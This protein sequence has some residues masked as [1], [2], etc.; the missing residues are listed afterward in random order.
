MSGWTSVALQRSLGRH[1]AAW[2]A[3]NRRAFGHHPLLTAL[4]V[5]GLLQKFG[6]GSE[7]LCRFE[8][9]GE[10]V[11]MCILRPKGRFLWTSFLPTQGQIAPT[12][13][14]D[15]ALVSDLWRSLPH[16]VV[17]I[18]LLCNDPLV[19]AVVTT[20]LPPTYRLNHALTISV[21]LEGSFE[22]Y[23]AA[24]PKQLRTNLKRYEKRLE[25]DGLSARL[26]HVTSADE[27]ADAV[28][29]YALLEDDGW[30]GRLGTSLGSSGP[31]YKF[32]RDLMVG[33]AADG[34]AS[35]HELWF[36]DTLVASRMI[37]AQQAT[38]VI[39]KTSYDER[40][41]VYA[42]GRMLLRAVIASSFAQNP[43]GTLE[44][45]TD[46]DQVQ[47]AWATDRRWIQHVSLFRWRFASPIIFALLSLY[48]DRRARLSA[49]R[50]VD[51][52]VEV[53][54][55]PAALPDGVRKFLER[56]E[57]RNF[58]FGFAWYCNLVATVYP[59]DDGIR[60]YTLHQGEHLL[61]VLP[62]RAQRV[63]LGWDLHA[64]G[65]F[66]TTLFEPVLEAG[67]KSNELI[68]LLVALQRDFP[69]WRSLTL[70][71]MD[72]A[73]DGYQTLL[74][75]MR[76]AGWFAFEFLG[77]ANW[78]QPAAE[79]WTDY[80]AARGGT[81]RSTI[82]RMTKKFA[83]DGGT[84]EIVTAS[85]EMPRAIAAYNEVY[86]ASWKRQEAFPDFM[87][88]LLQVCAEKKMLRLGLAWLNGK[89]IAAQAW[90][91]SHGRAEI[92]KVA[93]H[94][95]YKSYAPGTLVTAMLMQHVME[96]DHVREVDYL[97]GDDSYKKTWM[98]HRR[99]RWGIVAYNAGSLRGA[100]GLVYEILGRVAKIAMKDVRA[101]WT[102]VQSLRRKG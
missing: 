29:R 94:E 33:A 18:D 37:I 69:G 38:Q 8:R 1:G 16:A 95:D 17:Q 55:S 60:F 3:L 12:L 28:A 50:R 58:G 89:P 57:T 7:R 62:L 56:A 100:A 23:W 2:D 51:A 61:A 83:N 78:Y 14:G 41:A 85:K 97:I 99:E 80:L 25:A 90:I 88:G 64:L 43:D 67:V 24:R 40:F 20:A 65:N 54:D 39:L 82:K 87:P 49:D 92:Y 96:Q 6:D 72:P 5:D 98:S 4:F 84:L 101:R 31:Q 71:P 93:Y 10:L 36:D 52:V 27:M 21:A 32:Y 48:R 59:G 22:A 34:N 77:F 70:A 30:K 19:G 45:Y 42:P 53:F 13:I 46:A 81:L 47:L 75:A 66:Y 63:A 44:F 15:A 68:P 76:L 11:A 91:V 35:V 102:A 74:G 73:S 9:D 26:V 79:N 86:R